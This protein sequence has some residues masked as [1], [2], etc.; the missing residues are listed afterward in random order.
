MREWFLEERGAKLAEAERAWLQAQR[1][2]VVSVWEVREVRAGEGLVV[3]DLLRGDER[4]VQEVRGSGMLRAREAVLARVVD[5][6]GLSV[7]CGLYPR[8]LPP[9]W[10]AEVV[11]VARKGLKVRGR[12][13]V[14]HEKLMDPGATLEL[15]H[16]WQDAELAWEEEREAAAQR[17]RTLMNTDGEPLLLTADHFE[18][19]V[20]NRARVLVGLEE[21][22]GAELEEEGVPATYQF[23]KAGNAMLASWENTIVGRAVVEAASLRLET[24]SVARADALRSRVE[25]ACAGLLRFRAREHADPMGLV[26]K[27][28]AAGVPPPRREVVLPEVL[29]Q[30]RMLKQRHYEGWADSALPALKGKTPRQAVR[31]AAGRR[32]VDTLLKEM[33]HLDAGLPDGERVDFSSLR[34]ELGLVE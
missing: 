23:L 8:L 21:M 32:E 12:K 1:T 33:E 18:F 13:P 24:N 9:F 20:G 16:A 30:V 28:E 27:L 10:A 26:E 34:A 7:F 2:V 25:A 22:D 5:H 19:D 3:K 6:A 14:P 29:E 4:F 11:R 17:P 31:S 15:I